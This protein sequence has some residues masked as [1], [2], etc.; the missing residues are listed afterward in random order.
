MPVHQMTLR[1]PWEYQWLKPDAPTSAD[2]ADPPQTSPSQP[3][4]VKMPTDWQSQFGAVAGTVLFNR[5]F[6]KP[7]NLDA[8]ESVY[9]VLT[10]FGGTGKASVNDEPLGAFTDQD[11]HE[12]RAEFEV[13]RLL[14]PSNQLALEI[15]YDPSSQDQRVGGL[16]GPVVLEIRSPD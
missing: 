4:K 3:G 10:G 9:I 2:S 6:H 8:N 13:T 15:E 1:G 7:T 14:K 16:W 12:S 11:D 5:H